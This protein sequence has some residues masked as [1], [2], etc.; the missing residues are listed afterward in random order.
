MGECAGL[1]DRSAFDLSATRTRGCVDLVAY[2]KTQPRMEEVME[3]APHGH[4]WQPKKAGVGSEHLKV[5]AQDAQALWRCESSHSILCESSHDTP[6]AMGLCS[7]RDNAGTRSPV[8]CGRP[9]VCR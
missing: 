2:E 3:A 4:P 6:C 5:S 8:I 1:A 7:V 9:N